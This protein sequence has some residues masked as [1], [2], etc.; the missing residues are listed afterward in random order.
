MTFFQ[1]HG[2]LLNLTITVFVMVVGFVLQWQKVRDKLEQLQTRA[3]D[4]KAAIQKSYID[5]K[6]SY[7]RDLTQFRAEHDRTR[8]ILSGH[9]MTSGIHQTEDEKR[10][11][12][13]WRQ[14]VN[15]RLENIENGILEI[16]KSLRTNGIIG[17][18]HKT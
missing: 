5:L 11:R 9:L 7:L 14:Q 4:N 8:E 18:E 10:Y 1:E 12:A 17:K 13:E 16:H 15:E 2:V 3:D 6:E